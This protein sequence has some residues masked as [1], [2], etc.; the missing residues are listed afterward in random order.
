MRFESVRALPGSSRH[1]DAINDDG[2][3]VRVLIVRNS[4]HRYCPNPDNF[5]AGDG[6]GRQELSFRI[7]E[8]GEVEE[9]LLY[10][11]SRAKSGPNLGICVYL[12]S[13][14]KALNE[15]ARG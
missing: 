3:T 12:G 4:D 5:N 6:K 14:R 13:G 9:S 7:E 15:V 11:Q 1:A 8:A 10:Q 2:W